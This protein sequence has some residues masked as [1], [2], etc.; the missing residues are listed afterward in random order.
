MC[1]K[2]SNFPSIYSDAVMDTADNVI[3]LEAVSP[4]R[5]PCP[6]PVVGGWMDPCFFWQ[7]EAFACMQILLLVQLG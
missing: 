5:L 7:T 3:S 2:C 4:Q 6:H 1:P